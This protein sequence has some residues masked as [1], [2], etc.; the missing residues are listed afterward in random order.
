MIISFASFKGGVGKTTTA[1][2]LAAFLSGKK[3]KVLLVDGDPNQSALAWKER[4]KLPFEIV[5]QEDLDEQAGENKFLILDTPARPTADELKTICAESDLVIIPSEPDAL[6]LDALFKIIETLESFNANNYKVLFTLITPR[7]RAGADAKVLLKED[8][9]APFF[10][11]EIHRRVILKRAALE[12]TTVGKLKNGEAASDEFNVLGK[13]I[14][15]N[16]GK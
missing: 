3:N 2:H 16:Y 12:G 8:L 10:E 6:S 9:N 4:G 7:S 1:I 15:K 14:L 11:T 13:E 5:S